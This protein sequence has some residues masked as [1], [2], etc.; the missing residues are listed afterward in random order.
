MTAIP[1]NS[2]EDPL[3]VPLLSQNDMSNQ[4]I[5]VDWPETSVALYVPKEWQSNDQNQQPQTCSFRYDTNNNLLQLIGSNDQKLIDVLDPEDIIGVH[6]EVNMTEVE[7]DGVIRATNSSSGQAANNNND[8]D[9]DRPSNAPPTDTPSDTQAQ[10]ILAIYAY[11]RQ[12]PNHPVSDGGILSRFCGIGRTHPKPNP[13]YKRPIGEEWK[14]WGHRNAFHRRLV[15]V[16][17]EDM[18][19]L[20]ALVKAIRQ[21]AQITRERGRSLVIVNPMSGPKK[22]AEEIYEN[23]VQILMDQAG[24]DHDLCVTDH[25]QHAKERMAENYNGEKDILE[26]E[27]IVCMGGD[28]IV[29][30]V[31]QGIRERDDSEHVL[32]KIAIGIIGCGTSNG[33]AKSIAEESEQQSSVLDA[34]FLIAKG[35]TKPTDLSLYHTSTQTY[36]SFLTFSWAMLADIDIDS[37]V[38]RFLGPLRFDL[39]GVWCALKLKPYRAKLSYLPG[40][41]NVNMPPLTDPI[42]DKQDWVNEE[43]DFLLFWSAQVS[44]AAEKTH[45]SPLSRIDDGVFR[46]FVVR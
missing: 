29:H 22:N 42:P 44:H 4:N 23:T 46:I 34:C 30:E 32:R 35:Y 14:Q 36:W 21:A 13:N 1:S 39:W 38:L 9:N 5:M 31:L 12:D 28:G 16:A 25:V 33:M 7:S 17:S 6:V 19:A 3:A 20:N 24:I 18:M 2:E 15:V 37:E 8:K 41:K 11:P 40:K 45:N 27:S 10:A 43:D 26:Y